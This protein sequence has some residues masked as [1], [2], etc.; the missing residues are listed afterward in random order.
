MLGPEHPDLGITLNNLAVLAYVQSH[1]AAAADYWRRSTGVIRRRI[2]RGSGGGRGEASEGEPQRLRS[3]IGGLVKT[4]YRLAA[5][6]LTPN[7]LLTAEMFE[8]AQWAQGS[9]AAASLAQMAARSATGSSQLS[10]LVRERQDLVSEWQ[11][12]D[13]LFIAKIFVSWSETPSLHQNLCKP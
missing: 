7:Q 10:G 6:G 4:V 5:Q 11:V 3:E 12:K 9:E 2:E 1:W 8:T 13:K